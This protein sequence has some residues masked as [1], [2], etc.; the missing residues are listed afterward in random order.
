MELLCVLAA[1]AAL[2][3]LCAF[4]T[5]RCGIH[6][7]LAPLVALASV[8]T[9]LTLCSIADVLLPGMIALYVL[10][11]LAGIWVFLP[12]RLRPNRQA[13]CPTDVPVSAGPDLHAL[14]TPGAVL[15]W[16]LSAAF[17][18][19][20]FVRQPMSTGYD[21]LNLWST[22]VKLTKTDGRLYT[23]AVLGWP[24][25][26]TQTPGLSLLSY[27]FAFFGAFADWKIYVAYDVLAFAV[28]AAVLGSVE[29]KQYRL[30]VPLAAACWCAPWFL[31]TY[32]HTI[33]LNTVYM[34]SYGDIP[35][36]LVFGGAVAVWLFLRR[37]G[38]PKWAVLPVL[39][40]AA[41]IKSNTMVIALVA[42]GLI[43]VDEWLFCGQK[44][45][46]RGLVRR[47]GFSM[48]C[49]AVP[50]AL[51]RLWGM[52]TARL[53]AANAAS[54]GM[55][56]TSV[57]PIS[58]ALSGIRMLCGLPASEYYESRR[59]QF[60]TA[61][62]DMGHQFWSTDGRLSMVGQGCVVTAV[63]LCLLFGAWLVGGQRRLRLRVLAAAALSLVCFVGYNLVLAVSYGF[64]FK[65][66]Q[67]A[68]LVDY[69]RYIYSYYIGWFFLALAFVSLALQPGAEQI[70]RTEKSGQTGTSATLRPRLALLGETAVLLIAVGMLVRV[71]QMILPQL[72][73]LG[74]SDSEFADRRLQQTR[75][76][77]VCSYLSPDDRVFYVRQGD[78]GLAWFTAVYDFYPIII[79][80]S[81]RIGDGEPGGCGGTFGLPE[82]TPAQEG[83]Q[84]RYYH[85][86]TLQEFAELVQQSGCDYL[87]TDALDDIFVQSYGSLFTDGLSQA[88]AGQTDLY[89]VTPGGYEPVIM[90][91]APAR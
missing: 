1:L 74:F 55:G 33:Y 59:S 60:F 43:A 64:I 25:T 35:A 14:C 36:G 71:H 78:N 34:T 70:S 81:G 61:I 65:A 29:W 87:Y 50:V 82:L 32:N 7:A 27:F 56:E 83:V 20:F 51:S 91:E 75:A 80:K 4:F 53:V 63:I 16:G 10:C 58:A 12:A 3:A 24:W 90:E 22:A 44:P 88:L 69:N 67:A 6:S 8:A 48:L 42:A 31:T 49:L 38:G 23:T 30:A 46:R 85:P 52:Y 62:S 54:G 15:F 89:R 79:D 37:T 13:A 57:D 18:I 28:F 84:Q 19:Y 40:L 41:N 73:V 17:A 68:G 45:F 86:Y 77:Q 21:E 72:S 26:A 76:Q 2:F 11:C 9:W 5:L 66:D 39:A 47:T